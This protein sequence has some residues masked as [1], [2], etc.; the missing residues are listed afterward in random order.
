LKGDGNLADEIVD[1]LFHDATPTE[2]VKMA[3]SFLDNRTAQ[4]KG[5]SLSCHGAAADTEPDAKTLVG[6]L[7]ENGMELG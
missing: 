6:E 3:K 1:L 5:R 2:M 4:A 7:I